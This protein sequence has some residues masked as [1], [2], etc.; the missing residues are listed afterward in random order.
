MQKLY[1]EA[2]YKVVLDEHNAGVVAK[3]MVT[4][5]RVHDS[6]DRRI[7]A[8]NKSTRPLKRRMFN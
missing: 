1:A 2:F 7:H 3:R 6:D 4:G 5:K 8:K